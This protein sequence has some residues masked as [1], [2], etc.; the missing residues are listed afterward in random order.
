MGLKRYSESEIC[1]LKRKIQKIEDEKNALLKD[2]FEL[3]DQNLELE[4]KLH[5]MDKNYEDVTEAYGE[6]QELYEELT[7]ETDK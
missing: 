7:E 4:A 5:D 1:I 6:L 3:H 2:Y